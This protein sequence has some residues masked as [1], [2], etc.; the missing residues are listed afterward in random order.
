M[1]PISIIAITIAVTAGSMTGD[2]VGLEA[3]ARSCPT[4]K[5]S[6]TSDSRVRA[7]PVLKDYPTIQ[8]AARGAGV[9]MTADRQVVQVMVFPTFVDTRV[10]APGNSCRIIGALANTTGATPNATGRQPLVWT[11]PL[12]ATLTGA[13]FVTSSKGSITVELRTT[14][15][16]QWKRYVATSE[17][18]RWIS[19]S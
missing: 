12:P 13:R 14:I 16:G 17:S 19:G 11:P 10:A 3:S 7:R 15:D 8:T 18:M 6:T 9:T 1:K 5:Q 2:A 4:P